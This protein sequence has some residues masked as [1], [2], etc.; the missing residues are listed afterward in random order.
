MS[1]ETVRLLGGVANNKEVA[2]PKREYAVGIFPMP[3]ASL[4]FSDAQRLE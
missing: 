2:P 1:I 3:C 4:R